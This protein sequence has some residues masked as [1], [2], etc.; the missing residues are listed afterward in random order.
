MALVLLVV[1]VAS[2]T[3]ASNASSMNIVIFMPAKVW[4]SCHIV[5]LFFRFLLYACNSLSQLLCRKS[6]SVRLCRG[7]SSGSEDK[8]RS[9]K[10]DRQRGCDK[11]GS[12]KRGR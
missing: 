8:G 9:T 12:M 11:G 1:P 7:S 6:L 5:K 2:I 4:Y 10:R 3:R